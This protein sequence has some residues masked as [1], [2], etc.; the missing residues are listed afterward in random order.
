MA[1]FRPKGLGLERV[2]G[3]GALFSTA[4][5]NVGSSIYYALGVVAV[6]ALG[7]TPVVY[8]I[9]GVI[10]VMT[11]MTYTEATTNFPEAGG[12]SSFAR[13]A[14]FSDRSAATSSVN[15]S[16]RATSAA[17]SASFSADDNDDGSAGGVMRRL[18]HESRA[19]SS[20]IY[21]LW[22]ATPLYLSLGQPARGEHL[23]SHQPAKA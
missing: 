5:G 1:R 3:V 15:S 4:Y 7:L 16:I 19:P 13:S 6:F 14:A 17:I 21:I 12:S 23:Q 10:F 8:L 11:A 20:A 9:A 2:L 22:P 18:T